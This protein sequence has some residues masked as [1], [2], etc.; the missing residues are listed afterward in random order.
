[1][2]CY[3]GNMGIQ[4]VATGSTISGSNPFN[5]FSDTFL[6]GVQTA[7]N[8]DSG[9]D[10]NTPRQSDPGDLVTFDSAYLRFTYDVPEPGSGLLCLFAGAMLAFIAMCRRP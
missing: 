5:P 4:S 2:S 6:F 7:H 1:M 10:P 8:S 9:T 3:N